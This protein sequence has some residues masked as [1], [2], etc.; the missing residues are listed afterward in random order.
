MES[1]GEIQDPYDPEEESILFMVEEEVDE[2]K[3]ELIQAPW[4]V[5]IVDDDRDVHMLTRMVFRRVE[6]ED[7]HIEFLSAY[8]SQ[9]CR[10]MLH[11]HED[12]AIVLLDVVMED[13]EAGLD[14]I[15]YIR[16]D[17]GNPLVR[18]ILRTGQPGAAPEE[19]VI[20]D[21]DINDY[22][23]KTEPFNRILTSVIMGLR[24]F[25][26]LQLRHELNLAAAL[27]EHL[28][29]RNFPRVPNYDIHAR[30]QS[31][32]QTGGD[33]YEVMSISDHEVLVVLGDVSGKGLPAS[34]YVSA[35][36]SIIRAQ[37][38]CY[39]S[40]DRADLLKP[41]NLLIQLNRVL[42]KTLQRG[43]F[44]TMF[45]GM[46][47]TRSHTLCYFSAGHCP[48]Y[49]VKPGGQSD[50]LKNEGMVLGLCG[51]PFEKKAEEICTPFHPGSY[52][53]VNSDGLTEA[54]NSEG[55][56]YGDRRY[57]NRVEGISRGSSARDAICWIWDDVMSHMNQGE[58]SDDCTMVCV[59]R[60]D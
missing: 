54:T 25:R 12:I 9:D 19:S 20:L 48:A 21:Y 4:K 15:R 24:S 37:V 42:L 2:E 17:L 13:S 3:T 41:A 14:L 33:F 50:V 38:E 45:I 46:I 7:R 43:K 6:F 29:T 22:V 8:C 52:L 56:M 51:M 26:D 40:V 28:F 53:I 34:L 60:A 18:I 32:Q 16:E 39:L 35:V 59:S 47:D 30:S 31:A 1:E 57:R 5:L 58:L 27:E 55:T 49:L 11:E 10:D 44:V 36:L 23:N